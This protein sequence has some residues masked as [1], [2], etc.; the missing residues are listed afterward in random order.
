MR[1]I[2]VSRVV[3][4]AGLSAVVV[5][6]AALFALA[7]AIVSWAAAPGPAGF[8]IGAW[9]GIALAVVLVIGVYALGRHD[10]WREGCRDGYEQRDAEPSPGFE[11]TEAEVDAMWAQAGQLV[12]ELS[13]SVAQV[14]AAADEACRPRP[15]A[16]ARDAVRIGTHVDGT[17]MVWRPRMMSSGSRLVHDQL[18]PARPR[19]AVQGERAIA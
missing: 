3:A 17:P 15:S 1:R 18:V 19:P 13:G 16:T 10:G 6:A 12:A 5:S 8:A 11:A 4:A 7:G 14:S 9:L 2:C